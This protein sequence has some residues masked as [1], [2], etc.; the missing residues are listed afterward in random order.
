MQMLYDWFGTSNVAVATRVLNI[1]MILL[2][3][4]ILIRVLQVVFIRAERRMKA[5]N[6]DVSALR[7]SRYGA[8]AVVYVICITAALRH[9]PG[10]DA[11]MTSVLAGSGIVAIV[12]G[13]A[14]QEALGNIVSGV[15]LLIF[16]PFRIG[17]KVKYHGLNLTG[18][19]EEIG[20]RHTAI[21]TEAG[22]QILIPNS[23]MNSNVV[24]VLTRT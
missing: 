15:V 24:E 10:L 3:M 4:V 5:D 9:V 1:T 16:R 7:Y 13:F 18:E 6:K 23:L 20:F 14:S 2:V 22:S 8:K 12:V 21:R 19:I 17:D 11:V